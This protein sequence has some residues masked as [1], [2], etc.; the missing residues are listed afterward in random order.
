M[1]SLPD[2]RLVHTHE[3]KGMQVTELAADLSGTAL[4]VCDDTSK[5]IHVLLRILRIDSSVKF[6]PACCSFALTLML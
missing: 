2:R 1:R 5:A 3:L 6:E 4:A